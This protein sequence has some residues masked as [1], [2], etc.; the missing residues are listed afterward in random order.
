[1]TAFEKWINSISR[2]L[3]WIAAVFLLIMMVLTVFN[4]IIRHPFHSIPGIVEI[5]SFS[6][7]IVVFFGLA[8]TTIK[9][10]HVE[11]DLVVTRFPI[12]TQTIIGIFTGI[13]SLG[14]WVLIT[15]QSSVYGLDQILGGEFEPVLGYPVAPFRIILVIGCI[16]L[17][18]VLLIDL[19]KLVLRGNTK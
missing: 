9:K 1:M 13:L 19:V 16:M 11:V 15:W 8:Y 17:C 14:I 18:L 7:V 4:V 5:V 12:K 2:A 10:A 3:N 6:F